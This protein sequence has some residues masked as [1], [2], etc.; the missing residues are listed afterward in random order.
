MFASGTTNNTFTFPDATG[1]IAL[2]SDIPS[3][4]GYVPY[5]GATTNVTL[6]A[7]NLTA[8]NVTLSSNLASLTRDAVNS[9][10][11]LRLQKGANGYIQPSTLSVDRY[12]TLPD[13]TGTIA[14]TADLANYLPLAGGTLTGALNG[15]NATFSSSV[16]V[17]SASLLNFGPITNFVGMS[18][19][20]STGILS[21]YAN[22]ILALNFT[23]T[24]AASFSS[25]VTA[26]VISSDQTDGGAFFI[27]I[28]G[29]STGSITSTFQIQGSGSKLDLNA[30][31]YG[32]NPFGIWT[33]GTQKVIVTSAGNV[34]IG[35][36]SPAY[37]LDVSGTGRFTS[38]L[39]VSGNTSIGTTNSSVRLNIQASA[40]FE[41]PTLGTATGTMGYLSAN[42]LYGMY[43]GIGNSGNTWLQSQRNDAT[44]TAYNLLLNPSGG[45]VGIGTSSP[46][47]TA[48]NRTVLDINGTQESLLA[49]STGGAAKGYIYHNASTSIYWTEGN[50]NMEFGLAGTGY[51]GFGTNNTERMRITSNGEVLMNT[52]SV[53][54]NNY[55]LQ[56]ATK[57]AGGI[58]IR[59]VS[60]NGV[61]QLFQTSSGTVIGSITHNGVNT[62]YNITSDYRLKQDLKDY[63]GLDLVS[64]IKTYD[65]EW[66]S[67]K[68]RMYGVMAHE[69]AEV[70]PYAV[71]GEKD[72]EQMQG[73]D[74]SKIVPVLVKAI[75]E[76]KAEIDQLK[77]K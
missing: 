11:I 19:N 74:Y 65:Y 29:A 27:K 39:L 62:S 63:S 40:N 6:G 33:N 42:G 48:A 49:F 38:T 75:Q 69:L 28:S 21:L 58:L 10:G 64:A 57:S 25:T 50:R 44:A 15:I 67:D 12:Y 20:N 16:I 4:T 36:T 34:G 37:T 70:I 8:D 71:I 35:T 54:S 23:S 5:T 45:N 56:I 30:Y 51:M 41:T 60:G 7:F 13:A 66:K 26:K 43:I 31:V 18:G 24:A 68:T 76:L 59:D 32:A 61:F 22:N 53:Y 9:I 1:T 55:T 17:G 72:G 77:N 52:S 73:V 3:L 47:Y 46:S 2:T 14:L